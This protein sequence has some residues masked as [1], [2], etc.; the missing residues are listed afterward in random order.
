MSIITFGEML[1]MPFAFEVI[2]NISPAASR[3]KYLGLLSCALS[4][5]PLFVTPNLIPYIYSTFGPEM[6]WFCEGI[7]GVII[8]T[9]FQA[10]NK[11]HFG[12]KLNAVAS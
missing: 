4:S 5:I 6:L 2:T 3:G 9:G 12:L 1:M 7:I 10:L 8:L 11:S